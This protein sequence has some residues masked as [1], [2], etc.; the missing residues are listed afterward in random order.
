MPMFDRRCD[1]CEKVLI[2]CLEKADIQDLTCK[3]GG[4]QK[5]VWLQSAPCVIQ[6]SIEGGIWIRHGLCD[7]VTGEPK[8]YYSKT[9]IR[10]EE[11]RRNY[12]NIVTHVTPPGSDK[13]PHTTRWV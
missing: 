10:A 11:K 9:E 1:T 2:D 8:K 3:C 12:S 13:S 4:T 7:E 6:D 5:R